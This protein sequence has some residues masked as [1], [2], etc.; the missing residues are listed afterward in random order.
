MTTEEMKEYLLSTGLYDDDN[1]R[2]VLFYEEK[3]MDTDKT[4]PIKELVE[5]FIEIDKEY[6]G[7]PW[8]ILQI[9]TNINIII[10][11]EDRKC[12]Y[13]VDRVIEKLK[14]AAYRIDDSATLSSR[15]V[16]NEEDAID[17]VKAGGVNDTYRNS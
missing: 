3:M 2:T 7:R 11:V 10:P 1:P 12:V 8:N 16:V 6:E 15:D 4:V 9:L 14:E 13:D 5:R 17:I